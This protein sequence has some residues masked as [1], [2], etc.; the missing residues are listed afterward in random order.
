MVARA[1]G[2]STSRLDYAR[3]VLTHA[4]DL[5]D[6]VIAGSEFLDKAYEEARRRK[7]AAESIDA[8]MASLRSAAPDLADQV[9]EERLTLAEA[10]AALRARGSAAGK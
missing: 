9:T 4:P 8:Q 2:I 3:I 5:V 10:L 7:R 1:V 6:G